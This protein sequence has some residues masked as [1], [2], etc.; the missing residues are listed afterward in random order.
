MPLPLAAMRGSYPAHRRI[1][2]LIETPTADC[3]NWIERK[4]GCLPVGETEF[5]N[6]I[7][8]QS[9]SGQYG[10][11]RVAAGIVGFADLTLG[12]AVEPV[13]GELLI[14]AESA[15]RHTQDQCLRLDDC[16]R[17]QNR[18]KQSVYPNEDQPVGVSQPHPRPGL[19]AQ[20]DHLLPQ[21]QNFSLESRPCLQ[22]R[23]YDEQELDQKLDHRAFN[24]HSPTGA[25]PWIKFSVSTRSKL[26]TLPAALRQRS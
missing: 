18:G 22:S 11:T 17:I 10:Q 21:H 15:I 14:S 19:A 26:A 2:S 25:S 1:S 24:Y 7:A 4:I 6:G 13:C 16:D 9:A 20:D 12:A 3:P 5:V 8:A 23:S